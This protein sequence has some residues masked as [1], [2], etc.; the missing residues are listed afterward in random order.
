MHQS[1]SLSVQRSVQRFSARFSVHM[2]T[3]TP[4][5]MQS[6]VTIDFEIT[7]DKASEHYHIPLLLAPFGYST[8]RGS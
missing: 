1:S 4:A 2:R 5:F 3:I 7:P 6:Q 8:Y